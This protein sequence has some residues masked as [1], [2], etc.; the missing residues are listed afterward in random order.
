MKNRVDLVL[1]VA[2]IIED[3]H[4]LDRLGGWEKW[5]LEAVER[6]ELYR[7]GAQK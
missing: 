4:K 1:A 6:G 5:E 2:K 3:Y 7:K